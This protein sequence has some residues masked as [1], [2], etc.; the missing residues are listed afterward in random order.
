MQKMLWNIFYHQ[1]NIAFS[2]RL[3]KV[4]QLF[5]LRL[6][7]WINNKSLLNNYFLIK[8]FYENIIECTSYFNKFYL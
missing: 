3:L 8:L 1:I 7:F 2:F 4:T 6:L 5:F